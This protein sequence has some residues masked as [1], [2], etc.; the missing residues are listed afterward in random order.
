MKKKDNLLSKIEARSSLD[1]IMGIVALVLG[2][3]LLI[4]FLVD[5]TKDSNHSALTTYMK[6]T[7]YFSVYGFITDVVLR[8]ITG[9]VAVIFGLRVLFGK[10]APKFFRALF[11]SL[12][13]MQVFFFPFINARVYSANWEKVTDLVDAVVEESSKEQGEDDYSYTNYIHGDE[14]IEKDNELGVAVNV[15]AEKNMMIMFAAGIVSTAAF[16]VT[17]NYKPKTKK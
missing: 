14:V 16:F 10:S 11:V 2:L 3:I 17:L 1:L 4:V 13:I 8:L 7:G 9:I 12:F 5:F 15:M 6:Y